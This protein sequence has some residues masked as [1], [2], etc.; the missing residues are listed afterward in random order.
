MAGRPH[1]HDR[2][3]DLKTRHGALSSFVAPSKPGARSLMNCWKST[4]DQLDRS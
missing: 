3:P 1:G 2:R 4:S